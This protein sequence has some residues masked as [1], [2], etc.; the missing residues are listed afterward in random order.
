MEVSPGKNLN[1]DIRQQRGPSSPERVQTQLTAATTFTASILSLLS[2]AKKYLAEFSHDRTQ[3]NFATFIYRSRL[4]C[5][6]A[7]HQKQ[8]NQAGDRRKVGI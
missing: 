4:F 2:R 1:F 3:S 5:E 7:P 8:I 6:C